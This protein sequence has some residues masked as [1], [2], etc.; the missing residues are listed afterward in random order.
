MEWAHMEGGS[1]ITGRVGASGNG[2]HG[3]GRVSTLRSAGQ[4]DLLEVEEL[5]GAVSKDL[6]SLPGMTSDHNAVEDRFAT[7]RSCLATK[8]AC[9]STRAERSDQ[10]MPIIWAPMPDWMWV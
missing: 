5:R 6:D 10:P 2:A 1:Q 4:E 8:S 7:T 3:I 9:T